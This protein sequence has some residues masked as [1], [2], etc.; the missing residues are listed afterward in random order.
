MTTSHCFEFLKRTL[1]YPSHVFSLQKLRPPPPGQFY[2][3]IYVSLQPL[4]IL[5]IRVMLVMKMMRWH[6]VLKP[7]KEVFWL[8]EDCTSLPK[9]LFHPG[10]L[11]L[12]TSPKRLAQSKFVTCLSLSALMWTQ[13]PADRRDMDSNKGQGRGGVDPSDFF[14]SPQVMNEYFSLADLCQRYRRGLWQEA[15]SN[16]TVF[17]SYLVY[18]VCW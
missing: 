12:W 7:P 17:L 9:V 6:S 4:A 15:V 16:G 8:M 10:L 14:P 18:L 11:A 2:V 3:L 13:W 5:F 1:V